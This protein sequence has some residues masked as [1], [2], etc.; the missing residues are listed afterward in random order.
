MKQWDEFAEGSKEII[1][2][3]L[4]NSQDLESFFF[5]QANEQ[6]YPKYRELAQILDMCVLNFEI[7]QFSSR[8]IVLAIIYLVMGKSLGEFS[9]KD[10]STK[11]SVET[12][13][14]EQDLTGFNTIYQ[15]FLQIYGK[16]DYD[17]LLPVIQYISPYFGVQLC[18]ELPHA[19]QRNPETVL[20]VRF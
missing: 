6:S 5:K 11:F 12:T 14:L 8:S 15:D 17:E 1:L 10:I 19:A 2:S 4:V 13:F 3:K 20:A 16:V 18:C 7:F 9:S